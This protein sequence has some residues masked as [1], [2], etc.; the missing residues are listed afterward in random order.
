MS[1]EID[2]KK[3]EPLKQIAPADDPLRGD[4]ELAFKVHLLQSQLQS[5]ELAIKENSEK[6]QKEISD[7]QRLI[8]S[9]LSI[10]VISGILGLGAAI[11]THLL[12]T[13]ANLKL[14]R[15]KYEATALLEQQK[16][17]FNSKQESS[18]FQSSLVFKA[19]ET[20]NA[21]QA[22]ENLKFLVAI[23]YIDDPNEKIAN[24]LES[25][26]SSHGAPAPPHRDAPI[27]PVL[28]RPNAS[29][30]ATEPAPSSQRDPSVNVAL[31]EQGSG[32]IANT[33][34]ASGHFYAR[35][36]TIRAIQDLG[37]A[38]AQ[39]HSDRPF[40]VGD[41]SLQYGVN[42]PTH[43]THQD[44]RE[45][46]IR[47]FRKDGRVGGIIVASESYSRDLTRDLLS[48]IKQKYP[49]ATILLNDATLISEGLAKSA[50]GQDNHIHVR[51]P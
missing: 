29:V 45:F 14:E 27:R 15:A 8:Y 11:V 10:A 42:S 36:T 17:D 12:Q 21:A 19:I 7:K 35:G 6:S 34:H 23:G 32:Y 16:F 46:D 44:G 39:K 37:I 43:A 9:P 20:G 2:V 4:K 41:L 38:W 30:I 22:I 33:A 47:L 28:P 1:T 40:A 25:E 18:K 26:S 51:L 24:V 5:I 50:S 13:D 49:E 3:S 31:P 48:L